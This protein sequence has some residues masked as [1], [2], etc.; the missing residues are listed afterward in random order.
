MAKPKAAAPPKACKSPT[1]KA[2]A[3]DDDS[4]DVEV[5]PK[6]KKRIT[7]NWVKNPP[8]TDLLV[9]Y[10]SDNPTFR[11]KLFS[12]STAE[13]KKEKREK[14]VGKD[15]KA[16][17]CG[18]LA[19]YIFGDDPNE[20]VRYHND[21]AKYAASVETRLRRYRFSPRCIPHSPNF[22]QVKKGIYK[23]PRTGWW[24]HRSRT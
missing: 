12:D 5:L 11:I 14:H 3:T 6:K 10:L 2:P 19:K 9:Q 16:V 7:V 22:V 20:Q 15:G 23:A 8:W 1:K 18:T 17:Q 21:P 24:C 4:S 13:A